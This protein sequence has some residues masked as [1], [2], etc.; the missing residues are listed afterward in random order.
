MK[1]T[2]IVLCAALAVASVA[3]AAS[4]AEPERFNDDKLV[5][6]YRDLAASGGLDTAI[7]NPTLPS[8]A[9]E[10]AFLEALAWFAAGTPGVA[11]SL[12]LE[13]L[14]AF[15]GTQAQSYRK[16]LEAKVVRGEE[17][18]YPRTSTWKVIQKL[19]LLRNEMSTPARA[20]R[21]AFAAMPRATAADDPWDQAH[22]LDTPAEFADKVCKA[23][24]PVL[25]KFG[26]TN[27][28]QC[29]L[30]ELIGSVK[31]FA[32]NPAH[33]D[34]DVYKVWF[35]FRPDASFAARIKEPARLDDLARAEGV[36]SSPTFVVYRN[37]RRYPCGGAFPDPSGTDEH[38]DACLKKATGDAPLS[39]ACGG[40]SAAAPAAAAPADDR[41]WKLTGD[42]RARMEQDWDSQAADGA[43]RQDRLRARIRARVGFAY[44]ATK[45]LSF[46]LRLR[47]GSDGSQQSP[48]ITVLDFDDNSTGDAHFNFEHAYLRARRGGLEAWAGRNGL[49]AWKANE[50][51][52]DDD[53]MPAGLGLTY[54]KN[55]GKRGKLTLNGG[56]FALPAGMKAFTG[57]LAMGQVAF[58]TQTAGGLGLTLAG[59]GFAI[60]ANPAD[61]NGD[62]LR[63][64]N[65]DRDYTIWVGNVQARGNVAG[66]PLAVGFDYMTNTEDYSATD[67]DA[68]TRAHRDETAGYDA[69]VSWGGTAKK[70]DWLVGVWYAHIEALAV[71]T[72]VATDDWVRWGSATQTDGSDLKGFEVRGAVGLGQGQSIVGRLFLVE[73]LSSVQDGKRFRLDYNIAF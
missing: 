67:P 64:G 1:G 21:Y 49:P 54:G 6:S 37:G 2:S 71:N 47:S 18:D 72:S 70:K 11:G 65:G 34:V 39:S 53:V 20:G 14:D 58:A 46:G 42:F 10:P 19:T 5:A 57:N 29:M 59:G 56:Y 23:S 33:Q 36:R 15:A 13:Q 60:D 4:G 30:F 38:L 63:L 55:V 7:R 44:D 9:P 52:W 45:T 68:Y 3:Q 16:L 24:R 41:K 28:T 48:H 40:P 35:G 26:N 27:C 50:L 62:L 69:Y 12:T 32:E 25:V 22:T 31:A 73:A 8:D 43:A 51:F 61:P 66:K 17:N